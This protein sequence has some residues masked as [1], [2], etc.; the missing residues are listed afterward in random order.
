MVTSI[1]LAINGTYGPLQFGERLTNCGSPQ[2]TS[3][4]VSHL[5]SHSDADKSSPDVNQE[6]RC[7]YML[8]LFVSPSPRDPQ[9]GKVASECGS[10][11]PTGPRPH[12]DTRITSEQVT[13][14]LECAGRDRQFYV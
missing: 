4:L 7:A 11:P 1:R 10:L 14:S 5:I 13:T 2:N 8:R 9:S 12:S 6:K 3:D